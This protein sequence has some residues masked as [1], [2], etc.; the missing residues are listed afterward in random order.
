MASATPASPDTLLLEL[1]ISLGK[2]DGKIYAN[3]DMTS[4]SRLDSFP[5]VS[6]T[7][8]QA[9]KIRDDL[10]RLIE[11]GKGWENTKPPV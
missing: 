3:I 2:E 11:L 5:F 10:R 4:R 6:L 1:H 7:L 9:E 8:V